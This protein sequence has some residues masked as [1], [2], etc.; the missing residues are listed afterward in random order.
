MPRRQKLVLVLS[1]IWIPIAFAAYLAQFR[2]LVRPILALV[3]P[4]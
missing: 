4:R 3:M 1:W 2:D